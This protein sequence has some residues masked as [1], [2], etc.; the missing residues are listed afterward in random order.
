MNT[1]RQTRRLA[2]LVLATLVLTLMA[3]A[4]SPWVAPERIALLCGAQGQLKAV[5]LTDDGE[6]ASSSASGGL[7]CPLCLGLHAPPPV[8]AVKA[9][10]PAGPLPFSP[11]PTPA[12]ASRT[13]L[14]WHSRAPPAFLA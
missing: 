9:L 14:P 2:R 7:D 6:L 1:L 4:A 8:Q 11:E 13:P 10:P 5:V 3:A 12:A